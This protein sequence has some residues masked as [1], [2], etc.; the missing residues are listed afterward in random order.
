MLTA[1]QRLALST[2]LA[3]PFGGVPVAAAI[4]ALLRRR[5]PSRVRCPATAVCSYA[6][7]TAFSRGPPR[8]SDGTRVQAT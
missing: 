1:N 7:L 6:G 3:P 5:A 8:P 2:S 4:V